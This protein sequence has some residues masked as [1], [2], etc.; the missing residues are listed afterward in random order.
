MRDNKYLENLLYDIW[1][2]NFSDIPR[3]NI[4]LIKY[5]KY[6]K[7]QLGSIKMIKERNIFKRYIQKLGLKRDSFDNNS[8]SLILITRYFTDPEV[9]EYVIRSTIAHELCHYA[10]GFNSPLKRMYRYPHQGGIIKKELAKRGLADIYKDSK[11]W[12]KSNWVKVVS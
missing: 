12:L 8:I 6:S 10:H 4:V 7:R 5:G 11:K 1:E 3:L 9:P 2:N